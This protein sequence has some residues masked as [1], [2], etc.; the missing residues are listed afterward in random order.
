MRSSS[1]ALKSATLSILFGLTTACATHGEEVV[2]EAADDA[3][4]AQIAEPQQRQQPVEPDAASTIDLT[5]FDE[6]IAEFKAADTAEM[7]PACATL[8]VGSSSIRF[9]NTLAR[10]F[11]ERR[12]INRGFGGSTIAEVNHY[13]EQIVAPYKPAEIVFYAGENDLNAGKSPAA[14]FA[15]FEAFMTKKENAL[16]TTPVWY[17]AAK[18]SRL[19]F[20]QLDRQTEL[21]TQIEALARVRHDLDYVNVVAP[22]LN[23]DGA[24][25]DI[26]VSDDLH[27]TADGYAIWT[28]VVKA[29]LN[30]GQSMTAPGC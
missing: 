22:M 18:P 29:A 7:P 11:P 6:A 30:Q 21:N 14:V 9:W 27:M 17:I 10:D 13:F 5:R 8:F 26:F 15:D 12:V 28:P 25:K 1:L 3:P 19:R 4:A 16:G 24:P 23:D 20:D 2:I